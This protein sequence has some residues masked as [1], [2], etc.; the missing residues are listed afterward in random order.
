MNKL[1]DDSSTG[2]DRRGSLKVERGTG[3]AAATLPVTAQTL[4]K[5]DSAGLTTGTFNMT[6]DGQT[7]P[8]SCWRV[9]LPTMII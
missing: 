4:I 1:P 9:A 6:V 7:V 3:F 5:T 8:V 2:V